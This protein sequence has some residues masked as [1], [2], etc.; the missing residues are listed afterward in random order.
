MACR[1]TMVSTI[2]ADGVSYV[3]KVLSHGVAA[4]KCLFGFCD[5]R[6]WIE[7]IFCH[8]SSRERSV[9]WKLRRP[10]KLPASGLARWRTVHFNCAL[11][12]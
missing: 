1:L 12:S 10:L 9:Q 5:K 2:S 8:F 4:G 6:G 11:Y 3:R 7:S